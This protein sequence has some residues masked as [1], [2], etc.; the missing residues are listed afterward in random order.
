MLE[1]ILLRV[2]NQGLELKLEGRSMLVLRPSPH[3]RTQEVEADGGREGGAASLRTV[4]QCVRRHLRRE[5][6]PPHEREAKDD[7]VNWWRCVQDLPWTDCKGVQ[8]L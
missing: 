8:P 2:L 1:G 5:R 3:R 7:D 6:H 4:S